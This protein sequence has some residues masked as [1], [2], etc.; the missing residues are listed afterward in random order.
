MSA[1]EAAQS[2]VSAKEVRVNPCA[3]VSPVLDAFEVPHVSAQRVS[4][5]C[6]MREQL[7]KGGE[8]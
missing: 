2:L 1:H 6:E 7:N 3:S 5:F 8:T 4:T